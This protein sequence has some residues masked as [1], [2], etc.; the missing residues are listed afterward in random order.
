MR[1]VSHGGYRVVLIIQMTVLLGATFSVYAGSFDHAF[2]LDSGPGIVSNS[3]YSTFENNLVEFHRDQSAQFTSW[4]PFI[5]ALFFAI[6]PTASGVVNYIWARS[7]LLVAAF[8]LPAFLLY[9]GPHREPRSKW[10]YWGAWILYTLALFTKVEAVAALAVLFFWEMIRESAK[11]EAPPS[12]PYGQIFL[13]LRSTLNRHTL[14]TL[15]PFLAVTAVYWGLREE[16]MPD[17]LTYTSAS[18]PTVD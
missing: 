2:N 10:S 13:D 12:L 9:L 15:R 18:K 11:K 4:V 5:A 6:H 17:F 16:L 3:Y 8:L 7:S 1:K 14:S